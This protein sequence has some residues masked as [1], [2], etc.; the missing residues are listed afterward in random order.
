MALPVLHVQLWLWRLCA[1]GQAV[2]LGREALLV[3]L[4]SPVG[5]QRHLVVLHDLDVVLLVANG[6]AVLRHQAQGFLANVHTPCGHV[7]AAGP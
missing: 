5:G 7:A 4:S 3:R 2:V 1:V 6:D